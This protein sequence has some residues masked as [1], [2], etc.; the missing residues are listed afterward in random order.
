MRV[1]I[2][3]FF[4]SLAANFQGAA[5]VKSAF[6]AGMKSECRNKK[7]KDWLK[8]WKAQPVFFKLLDKLGIK[9]KE[10]EKLSC[11]KS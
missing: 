6:F 9:I 1:K 5:P 3:C 4:W 2:L 11:K 10:L 7:S 8:P